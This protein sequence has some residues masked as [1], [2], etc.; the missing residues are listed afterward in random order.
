[1]SL[2]NSRLVS[3]IYNSRN[4]LMDIMETRGFKVDEYDDFWELYRQLCLQGY[5]LSI[6]EKVN[7]AKSIKMFMDIDSKVQIEKLHEKLSEKLHI[8]C[9]KFDTQKA[10]V[11]KRPDDKVRMGRLGAT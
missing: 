9:K 2:E 3:E 5:P 11:C 6:V 8:C 10:I 1:M 7:G 4:V